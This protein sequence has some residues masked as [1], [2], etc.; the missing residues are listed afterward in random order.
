MWTYAQTTGQLS[1]NGTVEGTG[2]SGHGLGLNNGNLEWA[3]G[4][5]PIPR[6]LWS[7][8]TF[9]DHPHLGPIVAHLSPVDHDAH[10]RT[11]FFLH[12]DNSAMNHTAS[13]GCVI[14]A[15]PLR[16]AI[17]DSADTSFMVVQ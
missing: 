7:I 10:G 13:D 2:Y 16:E 14:L 3:H 8:G 9:F 15:R 17:R 5:G 12:G 4:S 1:H 11:A 6:G